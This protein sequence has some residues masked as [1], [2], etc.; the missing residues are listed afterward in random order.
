MKS[1][2]LV[3]KFLGLVEVTSGLAN[4]SFSLPKR[5]PVK[6]IFF[7]PWHYTKVF[8]HQSFLHMRL[9]DNFVIHHLRQASS[10]IALISSWQSVTFRFHNHAKVPV[11]V[12][13]FESHSLLMYCLFRTCSASNGLTGEGLNDGVDWLTGGCNYHMWCRKFSKQLWNTTM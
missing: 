4:A 6:M 8:H 9:C 5:Q 2:L 10:Q 3:K 12:R 13:N 11:Q 1:I 7:A